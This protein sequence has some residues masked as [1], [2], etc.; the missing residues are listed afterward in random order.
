MPLDILLGLQWGD[1]GKGKIVD[2]LTPNYDIVCRFQGGPNAGHS[3]HFDKKKFILHTIPSGIFRPKTINIIGN[4]VVIDPVIFKSEIDNLGNAV[5]DIKDRLFISKRAH[6]ILPTHRALDAASEHLKGKSKIGSTLKGIAPVYTDKIARRGLRVGDIN[7]NFK[8]KYEVLK[9]YHTKL[10]HQLYDYNF[11]IE[12]YEEKWWQG[13]EW[14]KSFKII[15][16]EAYLYKALQNGKRLLAEGAQGSMLDIEFGTYPF[17][18]SSN[19]VSS[20]V[21]SGLGVPFQFVE[22]VFGVFKA[23]CTR[24]GS[25][26]FPTELFNKDGKILQNKGSEFGTTTGRVRRCGWLDLVALKYASQING[27]TKFIMTKAD[28]LS[29]IEKVK[30]AISYI[31]NNKEI[32]HFPFDVDT[33]ITPNYFSL[34]AW[35]NDITNSRT[36]NQLPNEL[37]DLIQYIEQKTK[38]PISIVSVGPDREQTVYLEK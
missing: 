16:S 1:E 38:I 27:I 7:K 24:V 30:V 31:E 10:L 4:G 20:A 18:T 12:K 33:N 14:L 35:K 28:V 13:I 29:Y 15:D 22:N 19:T 32:K 5:P 11:D 37:I 23:Y 8:K 17:V 9:A 25:G 34:N 26:P 3:L 2:L 36:K 21:F 6:F